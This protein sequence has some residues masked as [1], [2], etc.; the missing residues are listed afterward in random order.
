M[1]GKLVLTIS[2]ALIGIILLSG[3][4]QPPTGQVGLATDSD[5][6]KCSSGDLVSN[7]DL[8]PE[9]VEQNIVPSPVEKQIEVKV[10]VFSERD[11]SPIAKATIYVDGENK[12]I[13]ESDGTCSFFAEPN[14]CTQPHL[15]SHILLLLLLP[16][17]HVIK[18][19]N[20]PISVYLSPIT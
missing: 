9:E 10:A 18:S 12:C 13:T 14:N 17:R 2:V 1:V 15:A 3:C 19:T 7:L 20:T 5:L 4:T 11:N 6:Y 16:S 8:C